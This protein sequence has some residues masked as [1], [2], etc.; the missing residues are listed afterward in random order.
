MKNLLLLICLSISII[1]ISCKKELTDIPNDQIKDYD[2]NIYHSIDIGTQT[3]MVENLKTTHLN[4][5][6]LVQQITV[7]LEWKNNLSQSAYCWYYN[8]VPNLNVYD[9]DYG[10]LYN[11]YAVNTNKLCPA[12]WHVPSDGEWKTLE[13]YLGMSQQEADQQ[14]NRGEGIGTLLKAVDSWDVYNGSSDNYHFHALSTGFRS[15]W[16]GDFGD[17]TQGAYWW[18]STNFDEQ[19]AWF[20]SITNETTI[21]RGNGIKSSGFSVRCIKN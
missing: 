19:T 3:W 4:D 8:I 12:G 5:G 15:G 20:R 14:Y 6:T 18:S 16:Y 9:N 10:A 7:N 1:V 17:F 21:Y 2:N 13:I 11:W